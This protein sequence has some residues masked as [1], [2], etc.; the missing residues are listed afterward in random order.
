MQSKQ[1]SNYQSFIN[2]QKDYFEKNLYKPTDTVTWDS[3]VWAS[4][5][6]DWLKSRGKTSLNFESMARIKGITAVEIPQDYQEFCKAMLIYSYR[7]ANAKAS[8]QKLQSEL[9]MLK[10]WYYSLFT[11]TSSSNPCD[12]STDI[13]HHAFDILKEN[14]NPVNL[15]D[16]YGTFKRLQEIVNLFGFSKNKL[17]FDVDIKY[18]NKSSRTRKTVVTQ[19]LI[20]SVNIDE[21]DLNTEKLISIQTFANIAS[22]KHLC[23]TDGERI[24]MNFLFLSIM[25]GFRSAETIALKVDCLVEK[26]L[27]DPATGKAI[28][29]NGKPLNAVG[30][31]YYGAKGA[32]ERIH[33]I[34]PSSVNFVKSIIKQVQTLTEP[35]RE[36]LRYIRQ[37]NLVNFLPK[38]IDDM[39]DELIELDDLI[40]PLFL[41][42]ERS[43]GRGGNRDVILK[44]FKTAGI[45][46]S[47][48]IADGQ[49]AL[50][51]YS[52]ATINQY[53]QSVADYDKENP[54]NY[55][56]D[57]EGKTIDIPYENLLFITQNGSTTIFRS[58]INKTNIIRLNINVVNSFLGNSKNKSVFEKY[59]LLDEN[60]AVSKLTTH[61]PRHN[62]NTFL[63]I[64]EVSE[65]LQAMLMGRVDIEQN[66]HYQHLTIKQI[67]QPAS[68]VAREEKAVQSNLSV[69]IVEPVLDM[70]NNEPKSP[71]DAIL[72]YGLMLFDENKDLEN[73][74]K[75]NLHTFD[76][77][78]EVGN[79]IKTSHDDYFDDILN[80]FKALE[81]TDKAMADEL[82]ETHAY[83]SPLP[84]GSC[85]RNLATHG[86]PMRLACQSG[87]SCVNFTVTGRMG[88]LDNLHNAKN[89]LM[90][91]S[92]WLDK[93][94]QNLI[95]IGRQIEHLDKFEQQILQAYQNKIPI[96]IKSV[97]DTELAQPKVL[98]QL[99]SL[100][101]DKIKQSDKENSNV[102]R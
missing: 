40:D 49:G 64:A 45:K 99:F 62:V 27:S 23:Q 97:A 93:N 32:G 21:N 33:W 1:Q 56:F 68:L 82:I 13:L 19:A 74:L 24:L 28:M 2:E 51:Y 58:L 37:K 80:A 29:V 91:Q 18:L 50:K 89:K 59:E 81:P 76:N 12:L 66:K 53:I 26:P 10:R 102:E 11:L 15:S 44:A 42:K 69:A 16:H 85:M 84:Y 79:F 5:T 38:T 52:K 72:E 6:T 101:Y 30:I 94:Q 98:A 95:K 3:E 83:L 70:Q 71:I 65:H 14:S 67:S 20:D 61:I 8:P 77:R 22:L 63:A 4:K 90:Q 87:T 78:K 86:C 54:I 60:D 73:N 34:E 35:Y 96:D 25:T 92:K 57:Y 47:K 9:I 41:S 88:E 31:Q 36:H 43:R 7:Q 48:E 100:E 75:N 39:T 55:R 17:M 46:P